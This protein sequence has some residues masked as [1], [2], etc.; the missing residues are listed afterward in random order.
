MGDVE[1]RKKAKRHKIGGRRKENI[2]NW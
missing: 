2:G 1:T